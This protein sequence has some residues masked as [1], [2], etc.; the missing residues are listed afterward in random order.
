MLPH[1][2][3][4]DRPKLWRLRVYF[5]GLGIERSHSWGRFDFGGR[6]FRNPFM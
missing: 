5:P 3:G 4:S 6:V 1:F 2:L